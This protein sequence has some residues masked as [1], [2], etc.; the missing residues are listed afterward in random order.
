MEANMTLNE[1]IIYGR[2]GTSSKTMWAALTGTVRKD[3]TPC[4]YRFDVPYDWDD[5]SSCYKLCKSCGI[6]KQQLNKVVEVFPYWKPFIDNWDK[7][8]MIYENYETMHDFICKL[9]IQSNEIRKVNN[10]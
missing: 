4:T 6:S 3:L 2:V 5:F 9:R 1:W 8:T 7:L 10:K